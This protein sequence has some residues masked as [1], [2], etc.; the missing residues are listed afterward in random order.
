MGKS[1]HSGVTPR[2]RIPILT[3]RTGP[4]EATSSP[5]K[6]SLM[7]ATETTVDQ[8][9]TVD[10]QAPF[11]PITPAERSTKLA[12]LGAWAQ[13]IAEDP[14]KAALNVRVTGAA[15]GAVG[16][17]YSA[18]GHRLVVDEPTALGG[19]GLAANPVEFA[20]TAL[21]SCQ[22]VTYRVWAEKLGITLDTIEATAD[23]ALDVRGFLG[24][25]DSVRP[26]F[27]GISVEVRVSGPETAERY[28]ELQDAVDAH[29]PVLDLFANP[30]PLQTELIVD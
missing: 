27:Q 14:T 7:S 4:G 22:V 1:G 26:G 23:G 29:C 28:R 21:L 9:P 16:S 25:D 13:G 12:S 17:V 20:L 5:K 18:G 30:T 24:L 11:E 3:R 10:T 15:A 2:E 19:E 8:I 6:G